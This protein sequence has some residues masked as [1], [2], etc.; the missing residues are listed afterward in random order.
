MSENFKYPPTA[1][2]A[3][4]GI[5]EIKHGGRRDRGAEG[6]MDASM[7]ARVRGETNQNRGRGGWP[8]VIREAGQSGEGLDRRKGGLAGRPADRAGH[9]ERGGACN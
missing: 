6:G 1:L 8:P 4:L 9:M 3:F 7:D 5:P 2:L